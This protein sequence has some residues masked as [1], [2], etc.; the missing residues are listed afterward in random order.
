[1]LLV[2]IVLH[3]R[4]TNRKAIVFHKNGS[5]KLSVYLC[6]ALFLIDPDLHA[7]FA[8]ERAPNRFFGIRDFPY[9]ELG[10]R[11]FKEKSGQN[12]GS[13]VCLRGRMPK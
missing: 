7:P 6:N 12:S 1:M 9:L 2:L 5:L 8:V 11:Y 4:S 10:T 13:K 3:K